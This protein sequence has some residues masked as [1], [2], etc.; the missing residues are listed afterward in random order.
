VVAKAGEEVSRQERAALA[1]SEAAKAVSKRTCKPMTDFSA[2][3]SI[4]RPI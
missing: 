2:D 1:G 4:N 3:A